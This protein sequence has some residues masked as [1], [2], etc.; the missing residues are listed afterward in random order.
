[1]LPVTITGIKQA[2]PAFW[3]ENIQIFVNKTFLDCLRFHSRYQQQI[4]IKSLCFL[5]FL[6]L[7]LMSMASFVFLA[8]L[9]RFCASNLLSFGPSQ[10]SKSH[11]EKAIIFFHCSPDENYSSSRSS[12]FLYPCNRF[13]ASASLSFGCV[14]AIRR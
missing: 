11:V 3:V 8:C 13:I 6:R 12:Q 2:F 1:M 9:N 7:T 4:R 10:T 14:R 5:P